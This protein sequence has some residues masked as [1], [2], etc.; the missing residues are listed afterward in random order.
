MKRE[1]KRR[2][3]ASSAAAQ[4]ITK[5]GQIAAKFVMDPAAGDDQNG[6][7]SQSPNSP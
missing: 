7:A 4:A 2:G 1:S 5:Y 3:G 6:A